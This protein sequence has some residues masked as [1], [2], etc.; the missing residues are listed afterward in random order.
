MCTPGSLHLPLSLVLFVGFCI[1]LLLT[2]KVKRQ[3]LLIIF[4]VLITLPRQNSVKWQP[5]WLDIKKQKNKKHP[6]LFSVMIYFYETCILKAILCASLSNYPFCTSANRLTSMP[7]SK[8]YISLL[9]CFLV[10][11]Q[12]SFGISKVDQ[13]SL[14]DILLIVYIGLSHLLM[15][16]FTVHI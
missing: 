8:L 9:H 2:S 15:N 16:L 5:G 14:N 4:P 11:R 6:H 10:P 1:F 13:R 3:K 12:H 7:L